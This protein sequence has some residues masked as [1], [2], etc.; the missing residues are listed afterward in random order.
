MI[1]TLSPYYIS[2][3]RVNPNTS[4][5]CG[6]YTFELYVWMG[7]KSAIP[8]TPDYTITRINAS[9]TTNADSVDIARLVNSFIEFDIAQS[10]VT[11]LEDGNNQYWVMTKV[12]YDDQ[13]TIAQLQNILLATRGYGYFLEGQNPQIPSNKILLE[14]DEFKV[15]RNGLFVLPILMDEPTPTTPELTLESVVFDDSGDDLILIFT[16][17]S[18][19]TLTEVLAQNKAPADDDFTGD[20]FALPHPSPQNKIV[21]TEPVV[22]LE[23]R[24]RAFDVITSTYVMSNEILVT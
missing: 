18:N 7:N 20:I 3:P 8:S 10:L 4:V 17:T 19:F 23:Y 13:P 15:N 9:N 21:I 16:W 6:S 2:I 11:S 12:F 24:I 22:G 1:K 14:G 5:T